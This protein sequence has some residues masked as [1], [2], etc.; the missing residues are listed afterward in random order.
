MTGGSDAETG[1]GRGKPGDVVHS[2]GLADPEAAAQEGRPPAPAAQGKGS[3]SEWHFMGC[4]GWG[5]VFVFPWACSEQAGGAHLLQVP[6]ST[7][8]LSGGTDRAEPAGR[9]PN[10]RLGAL[11]LT[12][13]QLKHSV[14]ETAQGETSSDTE[15]DVSKTALSAI[16]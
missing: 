10:V 5:V 9:R 12:R 15:P 2:E 14:S 13:G 1:R 6:E 3:A 4:G 16:D 11:R 8:P 7:P